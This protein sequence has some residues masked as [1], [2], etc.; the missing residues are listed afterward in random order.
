[1]HDLVAQERVSLVMLH[2]TKLDACNDLIIR[3]LLGDDFDY[4]TLPATHTCGGIIL[5]W[6]RQVWATSSPVFG[7]F[8]VTAKIKLL[9]NDEDWWVTCVYGPQLE[10]EKIWFLTEL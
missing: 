7:E 3:E 8:S 6:R 2:E 9:T 1:M 10:T 5:A 4:L